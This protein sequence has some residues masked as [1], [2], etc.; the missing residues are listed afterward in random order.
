MF[1]ARIKIA[2]VKNCTMRNPTDSSP[3]TAIPS[4]AGTEISSLAITPGVWV[5]S[6]EIPRNNVMEMMPM[7]A[8]VVAALRACGRRNAGTP[9]EMAST[10]VSAVAPD[11]KA[12]RSAN[13]PTAPNVVAA[14]G[15]GSTSAPIGGHAVAHRAS[16]MSTMTPIASTNPYVGI[17]KRTPDSRAP[18]RFAIVT[19]ATNAIESSTA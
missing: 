2:E 15:S 10:P 5:V 6:H 9:L 11:E 4:C 7:T 17:A 1:A 14:W 19:K 13:T 18:R 3:K 12:F 8:R 16:P